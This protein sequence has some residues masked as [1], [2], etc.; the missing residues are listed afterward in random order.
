[1]RTNR[2]LAILALSLLIAALAYGLILA[3]SPKPQLLQGQIEA[4][5]YNVSSKV[6]GRVE[7]VLVRRGDKV[8]E[9]DL[10]YAIYSPELKAKLMQAEGGRDAALAMQQEADNGA[11]KQQVAASKEQWLKAQAAAKLARTTFDRVEVLFNEGVLARQKRDEAFTQ[12]QAAKYTE[13]AALAMYQMTDEGARVETKAAAAGNARM[14]EGAVN[15]VTAILSDSQMRSPKTGEISEVLLQAGELA[16]SGFPVVSLIDMSDAWAVFQVREDQLKQ[17]KQGDVLKLT[18]PALEK[19][20][21]FTVSHIAVMG[22]FATWRA[23]ESGHDF[24]MRTFQVELRPNQPI[25]DLR[26]GM[27][28]LFTL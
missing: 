25:A 5:E 24:D 14:A 17:F 26:V 1:M 18:I 6:P 15:E 2:I 3:Y 9:G 27:S 20:V 13:Q 16:P 4:R 11:R 22:D 12:W 19:Q 7:E 23:T 28:V 8:T 21:E 10:L